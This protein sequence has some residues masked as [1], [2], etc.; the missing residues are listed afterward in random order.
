[1]E[2]SICETIHPGI[3]H[4]HINLVHCLSY[5]ESWLLNQDDVSKLSKAE[6]QSVSRGTDQFWR[7]MAIFA[8]DCD[9]RILPSGEYDPLA[10][11]NY[12]MTF[13]HV[14]GS[15]KTDKARIDR[16]RNKVRIM[17]QIREKGIV[18]ADVCPV[19]I[20]SGIGNTVK[21]I[22]QTTGMTYT[23]RLRKFTQKEKC[24]IVQTC[25]EGYAQHLIDYYQPCRLV[26]LGLGI[27]KAI[28]KDTLVGF[29]NSLSGLYEGAMP[30]PSYNKCQGR[31]GIQLLKDLRRASTHD[32]KEKAIDGTKDSRLDAA[33]FDYSVSDTNN[34]NS[35][36]SLQFENTKSRIDQFVDITSINR[37]NPSYKAVDM[38]DSVS[39]ED[40]DSIVGPFT[41]S[42]KSLEFKNTKSTICGILSV[43]RTWIV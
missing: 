38:W 31:R 6:Q 36:K 21:R 4:G 22:N 28:G 18:L 1:M 37:E 34:T 5:G 29:M 24:S 42:D 23:D 8:G 11:E 40:I 15:E 41:N 30:H 26:V 25:W 32:Q 14:V 27:E 43:P 20:Y 9:V 39:A 16:L 13:A 17:S 10:E 19:P 7:V 12:D 3:F 2:R 33:S 35:D